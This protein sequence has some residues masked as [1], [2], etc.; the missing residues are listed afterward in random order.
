MSWNQN[1]DDEVECPPVT[2]GIQTVT[3]SALRRNGFM[4]VESRPC[5]IVGISPPHPAYN[6]TLKNIFTG[7]DVET[8]VAHDANVEVPDVTRREYHLLSIDDT[9]LS[10]VNEGDQEKNS[11]HVPDGELG[12]KIKRMKDEEDLD[13]NIIV[14][15][16]MGE[17]AVIGVK[18][19]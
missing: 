19:V 3:A 1:P 8:T 11:L 18:Q 14:I 7:E 12:D 2:N 4:V 13:V 6:I 16:A 5:R 9:I 17:E 15:E 10:M